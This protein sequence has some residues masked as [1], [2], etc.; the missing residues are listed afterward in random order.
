MQAYQIQ[1]CIDWNI[2]Q[3]DH[4]L[5]LC[6]NAYNNSVPFKEHERNARRHQRNI[7]QLNQRLATCSD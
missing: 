5:N 2:R 1:N 7:D 4:S 3:R 6:A